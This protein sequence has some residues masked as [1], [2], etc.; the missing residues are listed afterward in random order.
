MRKSPGCRRPA[1]VH[2][3]PRAPTASALA[4]STPGRRCSGP[5]SVF[6]WHGV[7]GR[8]W[9]APSRFSDREDKSLDREK[10]CSFSREELTFGSARHLGKLGIDIDDEKLNGMKRVPNASGPARRERLGT[11]FHIRP[12]GTGES[13]HPGP[14]H[15][16][17]IGAAAFLN[18]YR[19]ARILLA[20]GIPEIRVPL[21]QS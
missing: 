2:H 14:N 6:R 4:G 5:S 15:W 17:W 8:R 20:S 9:K 11:E 7:S 18:P 10:Q 12:F 13:D 1:P 21:N 16:G 19:N 3:C